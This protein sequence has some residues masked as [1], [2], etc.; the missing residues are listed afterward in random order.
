MQTLIQSIGKTS[1]DEADIPAMVRHAQ[2]DPTAFAPIY[3]H[4]VTSVYRYVFSK[5][6]NHMEAEDI[7]AE[8]FM[9][10]LRQLPNYRERGYFTAW[11]FAIARRRIADF[12]R[13]R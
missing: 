9:D 8:V 1:L 10:E 13:Q 7:T 4:Y 5:I 3:H 11:L 6:G 2:A 12:Y